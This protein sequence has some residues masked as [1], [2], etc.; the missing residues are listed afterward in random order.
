MK[1]KNTDPFT[2]EN[3]I[4][5]NRYLATR[6]PTFLRE[7]NLNKGCKVGGSIHRIEIKTMDVAICEIGLSSQI[8]T[9]SDYET[10]NRSLTN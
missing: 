4:Q 10:D 7:S 3:L 2:T 5:A 9:L 8:I 1:K 6:S